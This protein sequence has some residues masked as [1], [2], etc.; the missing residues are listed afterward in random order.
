MTKLH[1][2]S[3]IFVVIFIFI[4]ACSQAPS[5]PAVQK[6]IIA[7]VN[8]T[9]DLQSVVDSFVSGLA[10]LGYV[11]SRAPD[12]IGNLSLCTLNLGL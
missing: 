11:S 9:L 7:I 1:R 4:T 2:S 6:Y 10:N 12:Q 8:A 3:T 5:T